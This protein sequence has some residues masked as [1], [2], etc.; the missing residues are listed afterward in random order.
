MTA[1]TKY[2][3]IVFT[4]VGPGGAGKNALMNEVMKRISE[5]R[6]LP[7]ATTRPKRPYE[8]E[9][10]EHIFVDNGEFTRMIQDN[11]LLEWQEVHPGKFYGIPR[12][13]VENALLAGDLLIADIEVVGADVLHRTY[14]ENTVLV[15]VQPPSLEILETRMRER[16]ETEA[17]IAERLD[18]AV[19]ELPFAQRSDY[20]IT[21]HDLQTAAEELYRLILQERDDRQP[22]HD[23]ETETEQP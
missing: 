2:P 12:Q 17:G 19:R 4:M 10:R 14:P 18:R 16:G 21:N 3:G 6:Q 15:F 5:L 23:A 11:E 1:S 7:T 22:V 20:I 13:T 9:G 8:V